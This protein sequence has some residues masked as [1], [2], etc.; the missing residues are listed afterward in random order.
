MDAQT[1]KT[2]IKL[3][4]VPAEKLTNVDDSTTKLAG[5]GSAWGT[6]P[7]ALNRRSMI[8][9]P[10]AFCFVFSPKWSRTKIVGVVEITLPLQSDSCLVLV[11]VAYGF[12][13]IG[14]EVLIAIS[15]VLIVH[16]NEN[17]FH[18]VLVCIFCI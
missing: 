6:G 14:P 3:T 9:N 13:G 8:G 11:Q 7:A 10:D 2:T 15:L 16:C 18:H 4:I 5:I 1:H 12:L 17:P